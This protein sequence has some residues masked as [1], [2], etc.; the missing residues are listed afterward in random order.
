MPFDNRIHKNLRYDFP[1]GLVVFLVALPLCLGI[2]LAS[3]AP[4]FS[5]IIAGIVGGLF[6]PILSRSA[7]AVSGPAAGLTA[8][9]LMGIEDAGGFRP[10]LTALVLAGVFQFFLGVI[11][12][13]KIAYFFPI[14]VI[15]GM[16]VAIGIILITNQI[17]HLSGYVVENYQ[18]DRILLPQ[19]EDLEHLRF[20]IVANIHVGAIVISLFSLTILLSWENSPLSKFNWLPGALVVVV[21]GTLLNEVFDG[22]YPILALYPEHLVQIP[23]FSFADPLAALTFPDFDALSNRQIYVLALTMAVIASLESLLT[24]EAVDKI[25]PFKRQSDMNKELL[26]QGL[27]NTI[28]GLIGGLPITCVIV[29]SSVSIE[30]GGRTRMVAVIHGLFMLISVLFLASWLNRI[31]LAVLSVIL[32]LVGY[33]L[34][35]PSKFRMIYRR[36]WDQFVPFM[37]TI[38]AILFTDLLTGV[39]IGI[40]FGIIFVIIV[41]FHSAIHVEP[42]PEGCLIVMNKDVSFLNKFVLRQALDRVPLGGAVHLDA[43]RAKFIDQDILQVIKDFQETAK[44]RDITFTIEGLTEERFSIRLFQEQDFE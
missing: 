12:L 14:S 9:V 23:S 4:L 36:G 7:L 27:A 21:L 43:R 25:D 42:R 13:G 38:I 33:K 10:F 41:D 6:V 24:V 26:G 22:Y 40:G 32:L 30:S 16:L 11:K 31:P 15:K 37:M 1:A 3:G 44:T 19:W 28:S 34:A 2:A 5:G 8:I 18:A 29:R 39:V 35:H 20:I 17:P